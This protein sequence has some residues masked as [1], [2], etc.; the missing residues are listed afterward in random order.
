MPADITN[1]INA[2]ALTAGCF[3]LL[4]KQIEAQ[5]VYTDIDDI[6]LDSDG[7]TYLLDINNDGLMDFQFNKNSGSFIWTSEFGE[8]QLRNLEIVTIHPY[9]EAGI[10]N[11]EI[12]G[13]SFST[14]FSNISYWPYAL[15]NEMLVNSELNF[16]RNYGRELIASRL[17]K[18]PDEI[19]WQYA[20]YWYPEMEN[21]FLGI[22]FMDVDSNFHYGWIRCSVLENGEVFVITDHAY[23]TVAEESIITGDTTAYVSIQSDTIATKFNLTI[24]PIPA[25]DHIIIDYPT[26]T[27]TALNIYTSSGAII[28]NNP[29]WTGEAIDISNFPPAMYYLQLLQ[30]EKVGYGC[31][32]KE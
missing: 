6:I 4:H 2:Y 9:T 31:F 1:R 8:T 25:T 29:Y 23:E 21:R 24:H 15:L 27:P 28:Y 19:G 13:L 26:S 14:Y 10:A 5:V 16:N 17:D 30:L 7:E 32:V 3:L 12:A 18:L 11:N 22:H 20:G